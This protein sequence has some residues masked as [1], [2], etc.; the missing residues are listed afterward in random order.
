MKLVQSI[1]FIISVFCLLDAKTPW[2]YTLSLGSGYDSNVMRFSNQEIDGVVHKPGIMGGSSHFDS[3]VTKFGISLQKDLWIHDKRN[4]SIW[5]KYSSSVY[6]NTPEKKYWS[7]GLNIIYRW[8]SYKNL[9]YSLKHLD[10]FYLRHYIDRDVS[11]NSLEA[12]YF[13]DR[14]QTISLTRRSSKYSWIST[15]IGYLQRYY[16]KPFTEFDLDIIYLKARFNYKLKGL[17]TLAFQINQGR[18]KSESHLGINRPSSFDR[19]YDTRELYLPFTIKYKLPFIHS[20]GLSLRTERRIYDAEDPNDVLHAGRS[21]TDTKYSLWFR[22][23]IGE[24]ISVKISSRLRSRQTDSS[25]AWVS[26]LKSFKQ[27]QFWIN[28]EW[29]MIYDRY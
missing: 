13:S 7:G 1:S 8:G 11:T 4:L 27:S 20:L 16:S 22:K 9:K 2:D 23:D 6:A 3:F 18:A 28:I 15:G 29:D 17:G 10:N 21:H 19:S 24:D 12:C 5:S 25:Y 14:D 26:D